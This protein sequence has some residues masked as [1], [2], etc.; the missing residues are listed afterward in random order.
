M[1]FPCCKAF[2]RYAFLVTVVMVL[3]CLGLTIW[4][5]IQ[6]GTADLYDMVNSGSK[7]MIGMIFLALLL[8]VYM[9][10]GFLLWLCADK[11]LVKCLFTVVSTLT[12]VLFWICS[13]LLI[14]A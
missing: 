3:I 14:V 8:I 4:F 7:F 6:A 11:I 9:I 12:V 10:C 1:C 5:S 2:I 13:I